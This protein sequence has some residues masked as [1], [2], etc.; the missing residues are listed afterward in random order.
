MAILTPSQWYNLDFLVISPN[1]QYIPDPDNPGGRIVQPGW[2]EITTT[3]QLA[4]VQQQIQDLTPVPPPVLDWDSFQL[5]TIAQYE[6]L[7]DLSTAT[8]G[9][10]ATLQNWIAKMPIN[11]P[12]AL[13]LFIQSWNAVA[14]LVPAES[15]IDWAGVV[16]A[17][18]EY[19]CPV[20]V[21]LDPDTGLLPTGVE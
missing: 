11:R 1:P 12:E 4:S 9:V 3:E 20:F 14:G 21:N 16:A 13:P 7:L 6:Q 10:K 15:G 18:V 8:F 17:A 2:H 19:H 5:A